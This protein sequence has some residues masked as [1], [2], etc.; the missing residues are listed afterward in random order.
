[1][2]FL[3]NEVVLSLDQIGFPRRMTAS[4]FKALSFSAVLRLG[5]ELYAEFPLLHYDRPGRALRLA[6]LL[7]AK[8][9]AVNGALFLAPRFGCAPSEVTVRLANTSME[10]MMELYHRQQDGHLDTV[11]A[12]RQVWRRLAA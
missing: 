3:M 9:P 10:V 2:Y 5:Q 11:S 6:A 7:T 4:R 12:D 8:A 1:M